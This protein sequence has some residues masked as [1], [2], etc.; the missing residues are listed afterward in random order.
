M[1]TTPAPVTVL[2]IVGAAVEIGDDAEPPYLQAGSRTDG[3]WDGEVTGRSRSKNRT[4]AR[5]PCW[6]FSHQD[7]VII[8]VASEAHR[9]S[10][11]LSVRPH[12]HASRGFRQS[13][14]TADAQAIDFG[15]AIADS[16]VPLSTLSTHSVG[17]HAPYEDDRQ[18]GNKAEPRRR[19]DLT[20]GCAEWVL[21]EPTNDRVGVEIPPL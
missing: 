4:W 9:S 12:V 17:K 6:V 15:G 5:Q 13:T 7:V 18:A 3:R 1:W 14:S 8:K 10:S 21:A 20:R 16:S 11:L 19:D 2:L